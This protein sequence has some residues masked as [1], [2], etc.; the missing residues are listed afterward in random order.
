[1][2]REIICLDK[3]SPQTRPQ[4][5]GPVLHVF[6][7]KFLALKKTV[8]FTFS[9][10]K[11]IFWNFFYIFY[12]ATFQCGRYGIFKKKFKNFFDPEKLK[13]PLK[14]VAHNRLK[15]FYYTV[16]PRPTAHSP[17]L[18]FRIMKSWDQR[19]VLLS[20]FLPYFQN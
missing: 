13:K 7:L 3:N 12:Y 2:R 19:S 20:V 1:M 6:T 15:P 14:K 11:K 8:F 16:Q 5:S 9:G 4:M 18:I 17:K 10:S